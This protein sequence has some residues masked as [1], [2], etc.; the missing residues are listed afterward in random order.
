M[1]GKPSDHPI[2]VLNCSA[3][4]VQRCSELAYTGDA[5]DK[6]GLPPDSLTIRASH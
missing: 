6:V 4:W 5:A 1:Y 2:S 3:E